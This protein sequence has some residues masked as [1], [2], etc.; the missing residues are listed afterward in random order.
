MGN[1]AVTVTWPWGQAK[2][3]DPV[4]PL[5]RA[6]SVSESVISTSYPGH[7]M[8]AHTVTAEAAAAEA[9]RVAEEEAR[10][11]GSNPPLGAKLK[12]MPKAS[13][14]A[15]TGRTAGLLRLAIQPSAPQGRHQRPVDA[16]EASPEATPRLP[17]LSEGGT[18]APRSGV[19][20]LLARAAQQPPPQ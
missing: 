3:E 18:H 20:K 19:A 8:D 2:D 6:K 7:T 4:P 12:P 13:P 9:R 15:R 5:P 11:C 16:P 14:W 10:P 17:A 1:C